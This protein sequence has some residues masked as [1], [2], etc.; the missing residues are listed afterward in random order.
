MAGTGVY[1]LGVDP[2]PG[3]RPQ[4]WRLLRVAD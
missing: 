1:D 3:A 2:V 4:Q